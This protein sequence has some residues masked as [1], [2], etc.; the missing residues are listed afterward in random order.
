MASV[1]RKPLQE[2]FV[3]LGTHKNCSGDFIP[4]KG[5]DL[6]RDPEEEA[7][8]II[9]AAKKQADNIEQTAYTRGFE[10]GEKDGLDFGQQKVAKVIEKIEAYFIELS[11]TKDMMAKTFEKDFLDI[12]FAISKKVIQTQVTLET[13]AVKTAVL[14]AIGAATEK[15][16]LVVKINPEDDKFIKEIQM[17][18]M[19]RFKQ[20]KKMDVVSD[21]GVKKGGCLIETPYGDVDATIDTKLH[22]IKTAIETAY[23]QHSEREL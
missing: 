11:K 17:D 7:K 18:A 19:E 21:P 10:Q 22:K 14:E 5:K 9:R 23:R 16:R 3:N 20:I 4:F 15:S 13:E 2:A 6:Q 12:V 1:E 8:K